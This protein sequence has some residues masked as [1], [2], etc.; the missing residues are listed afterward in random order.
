V[1]PTH[2]GPSAVAVKA[3]I[4][5]DPRCNGREVLRRRC[6]GPPGIVG[7]IA[8][9]ECDRRTSGGCRRTGPLSLGDG[10]RPPDRPVRHLSFSRKAS[11]GNSTTDRRDHAPAPPTAEPAR[12]EHARP[13]ADLL[14]RLCPLPARSSDLDNAVGKGR[15]GSFA[16]GPCGKRP[17]A[18]ARRSDQTCSLCWITAAVGRVASVVSL[19]ELRSKARR[20]RLWRFRWLAASGPPRRRHCQ[21]RFPRGTSDE[22]GAR[23]S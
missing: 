19:G 14:V 4:R 6:A 3:A 12:R 22:A 11:A 2:S 16:G 18:G 23:C 13:M 1:P 7:T 15:T 21:R 8:L 10:Y 5:P 9:E 20:R 17:D